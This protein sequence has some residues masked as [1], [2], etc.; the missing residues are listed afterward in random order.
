MSE[1]STEQEGSQRDFS[2]LS[3]DEIVVKELGDK[4]V[5]EQD[6]FAVFEQGSEGMIAWSLQ[7]FYREDGSI[8]SK[9]E[10]KNEPP[11]LRIENSEGNSVD[12]MLTREFVKSLNQQLEQVR[13]ATYG[14]QKSRK[15]LSSFKEA[16][17][18]TAVEKP[19]GTVLIGALII[20]A[21][22]FLFV[23]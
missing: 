3:D 8:R 13:L 23:R 18:A 5:E 11:L 4:L 6:G 2:Q 7:N 9:G 20:L 22:L 17:V 16:L 12:F 19:L 1:N 10:L 14:I 15:P 21:P